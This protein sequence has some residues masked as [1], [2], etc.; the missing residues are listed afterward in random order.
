[1]KGA[2]RK[3]IRTYLAG[4]A[5]GIAVHNPASLVEERGH[6]WNYFSK[7]GTYITVFAFYNREVSGGRTGAH[8]Q[9]AYSPRFMH[10]LW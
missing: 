3:K 5:H 7:S 1:M 2:V 4:R 9:K 6:L 8:F 10:N